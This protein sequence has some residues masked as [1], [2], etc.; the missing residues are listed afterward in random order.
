MSD[1][2][3]DLMEMAKEAFAANG[4][5]ESTLTAGFREILAAYRRGDRVVI[6]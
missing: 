6:Q 2:T 3:I 1:A 5:E 4:I